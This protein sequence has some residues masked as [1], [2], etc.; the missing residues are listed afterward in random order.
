M[1]KRLFD[2][3]FSLVGLIVLSPFFIIIGLAI[4]ATSPGPVFSRQERIGKGFRPFYTYDFRI[5][6]KDASLRESGMIFYKDTNL[7]AIGNVLCDMKLDQLP[8]L[9]NVV[10]GEMSL[11][12]PRPHTPFYINHFRR[13]F[14]IILQVRP[15]IADLASL[16]VKGDA[17]CL[18]QTDQPEVAYLESILPGKIKV[19]KSYVLHK[20]FSLDFK[21]MAS[22]SIMLLLSIQIPFLGGKSGKPLKETVLANRNG[23]VFILNML[24]VILSY[25]LAFLLRFDG[26]IPPSM[27]DLFQK[28]LPIVLIFRLSALHCFGLTHGLWRYA[29]ITDLIGLGLVTFISSIGIWGVITFMSF[30]GYP[31]SIYF[32]D[33]LLAFLLAVSLRTVKHVYA[34]ITRIDLD[35]RKVL[36]IGAGRGGAAIV[37]DMQQ[38]PSYNRKPIAFIDEDHRK[39]SLRIHNIPVI[40]DLSNLETAVEKTRP[41]EILIAIPSATPMQIKTIIGRCKSFGLPIKTLPPLS[42]ILDGKV[43]INHI[44]NLDI[45]DLIGRR[46]IEI[47]DRP[48]KEHLKGKRILVTGAGGSIGS[49]L[50]RQIA[51]YGPNC[52]ILF[53]QSENNLYHIQRDLLERHPSLSC[54]AVLG[55]ILDEDKIEKSFSMYQPQI[56]FHA[57]AYKHVPMMEENPLDAVRN[58]IIGSYRLIKAVDRHRIETFILISSDKAV[59]PSSVMGATK[60]V[61][62]MLVRF[63]NSRD[64][65]KFVSVRFG[66]VLESNGS[67]VPLFREQIRRGG[68]VKITHPEIQRYFISIQEAVQLVLHAAVLGEGG[69]VFVLDMGKPVKIA[70]LARTMITLSGFSTNDIGTEFTGLRAGEKLSEDLFEET[71]EVVQTCHEKIRLAKNGK[72]REDMLSY[73]EEFMAMNHPA[74]SAKIKKLLKELVPTYQA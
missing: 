39:I 7:T 71:E 31:R 6:K 49:E 11:V 43:S 22:L 65:T 48:I 1:G 54:K 26:N 32:I 46:E 12:G 40:G 29:G 58:N 4:K 74:D 30:I 66:N 17:A 36:V 55:D 25:Y 38:N 27:V 5:L 73:V 56:V 37:R 35:A 19:S 44:R 68:P 18:A 24:A 64:K 34:T 9:W 33:G 28:T 70:D 21:I 59:N 23:I 15:G 51:T 47:S 63:F 20:S 8:R 42:D 69:E 16:Y 52:L 62:E 50:C 13:D 67:V 2:L 41:D 60:R 57:A 10:K 53:E 3:I 72:V 14:E 45:E 61:A